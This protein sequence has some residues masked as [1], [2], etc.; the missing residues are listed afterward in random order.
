MA[1]TKHSAQR[2]QFRK[3]EQTAE[4]IDGL[5]RKWVGD[6]WIGQWD[7]KAVYEWNGIS[8]PEGVSSSPT[9]ECRSNWKYMHATV[10]FDIPKM[11]ELTPSEME[12]VVV[13]ELLHC[14]VNE[15]RDWDIDHEERVVSHLQRIVCML[16]N[17]KKGK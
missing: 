5:M 3:H 12:D 8:N 13:H 17:R 14:V 2:A 4:K 9:A 11:S 1:K 16:A 15:M 10:R 7:V 6:L